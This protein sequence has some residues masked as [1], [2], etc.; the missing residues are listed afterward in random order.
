MKA[1]QF[2]QFQR[3]FGT[4]CEVWEK[5]LSPTM[6]AIYFKVLERFSIQV[7][8]KSIMQAIG[9][10]KFFPKPAELLELIHGAG[11]TV[12]DVALIQATIALDA[13]K[14]I[15]G[16]ESVQFKDPVTNAVI[17]YGFGG[18]VKLCNELMGDNEKWFLKDFQ[19]MYRSFK[20]GG[21]ELAGKLPGRIEMLN[22]ATGYP[23]DQLAVL[24]EDNSNRHQKLLD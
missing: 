14:R 22:I 16:Y 6:A 7:V 23:S 11:G 17:Q 9:T 2:E 18:W 12:E 4:M 19:A 13:I 20:R 21:R 15:G 5:E 8:E 24:I 1:D 10:C 3:A